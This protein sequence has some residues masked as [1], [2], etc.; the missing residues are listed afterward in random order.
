MIEKI[1]LSARSLYLFF[2][3]IS[4]FMSGLL[5]SWVF[6]E[7]VYWSFG[8]EQFRAVMTSNHGLL[9]KLTF[10]ASPL[11]DIFSIYGWPVALMMIAL[12]IIQG[13]SLTVLLYVMINQRKLNLQLVGSGSLAGLLAVIGFGCPTCGVS[14]ITPFVALFVS[15]SALVVSELITALALPVAIIV[16]VFGLYHLGIQVA[17]LEARI[18][19]PDECPWK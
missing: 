13:F 17:N 9:A 14:L 5:L 12:S 8:F 11:V 2:S 16:G 15:G 7:I 6:F 19:N 4:Q 3:R 1:R 10:L 18:A